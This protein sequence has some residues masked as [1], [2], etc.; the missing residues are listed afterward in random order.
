MSKDLIS[1]GS[2]SKP[3]VLQINEYPQWRLRMIQFL[4]NINKNL[5]KS[6]KEG[7]EK[8]HNI[9]DAQHAIDTRPTV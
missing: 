8:P 4:N 2:K 3:S 7:P 1:M 6:I 5:M 9:V